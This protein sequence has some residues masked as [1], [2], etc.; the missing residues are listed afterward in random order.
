MKH[1]LL[2][3]SLLG[4]TIPASATLVQREWIVDGV[5]REAGNVTASA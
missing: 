3:L 4:L 1:L 5:K 2:L